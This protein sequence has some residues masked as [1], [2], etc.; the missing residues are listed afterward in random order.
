MG[1]G[2]LYAK[3]EKQKEISPFL[4]G[5][6]I[7]QE[8]SIGETSFQGYPTMLEAGTPNVVGALGLEAAIQ[9]IQSIDVAAARNHIEALSLK[10]HQELKK[11][12][13]VQ[14]IS[15]EPDSH[16]IISINLHEV[17]PHDVAS[18]LNSSHIA[19]RA[20]MHCTQ[21]LLEHLEQPATVR[22]SLS[23]YNTSDEIDQLIKALNEIVEFWR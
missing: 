9:Y 10:A 11:I 1:I 4:V 15:P 7:V 5:G 13:E 23:I 20:G 2:V 16:G 18:F 22:I 14:I 6:G 17:H 3:P 21:P 12:K 8:V 19:V